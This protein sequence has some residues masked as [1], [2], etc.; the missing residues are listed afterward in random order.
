MLSSVNRPETAHF[1]SEDEK[2]TIKANVEAQTTDIGVVAEWQLFFRNP[3][4]YVWAILYVFTCTTTYSVGVFSPTFVQAF[5]P[6]WSVPDVQAQVVPI[7]AVSSVACLATSILA[8][9]LDHRSGFALLGFVFTII[10]FR[11]LRD[12]ITDVK[13]VT[14]MSL[15]FISIGTFISLP[16]V[17][18]LTLLNLATP[19]Q[20]A[21]G[22]GFVVG[23][24][25]ISSYIAAWVF[26]SS[27]GPAY[28]YGMTVGLILTCVAAVLLFFTAVCVV[29]QNKRLDRAE[30]RGEPIARPKG[31]VARYRI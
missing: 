25:N 28:R 30:A 29:Y 19:F 15:Y 5:H 2:S 23:V 4:N 22:V 3:L 1:L 26:R 21:I 12:D 11:I 9:R 13:D 14:M 10:G 18:N 24:G 8:D 31:T 20:R 17:W 6:T 27:E 7:F 16:M